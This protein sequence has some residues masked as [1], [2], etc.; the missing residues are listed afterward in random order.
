MP[1]KRTNLGLMVVLALV[2]AS[3]A[4][5]SPTGMIKECPEGCR[6]ID[7]IT[8]CGSED[9]TKSCVMATN[10]DVHIVCI[11][12]AQY[13]LTTDGCSIKPTSAPTDVV[14]WFEMRLKEY[15]S[16]LFAMLA[17]INDQPNTLLMWLQFGAGTYFGLLGMRFAMFSTGVLVMPLAFLVS[18]ALVVGFEVKDSKTRNMIILGTMALSPIL[19]V[20]K[21][22][23]RI[24]IGTLLFTE[25]AVAAALLLSLY[26]PTIPS[27]SL[28]WGVLAVIVFLPPFTAAIPNVTVMACLCLSC[29]LLLVNALW[30]AS[31]HN[32]VLEAFRKPDDR[33]FIGGCAFGAWVVTGLIQYSIFKHM[34]KMAKEEQ[35]M[36]GLLEAEPFAGEIASEST[37]GTA[38]VVAMQI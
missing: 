24:L 6:P 7:K 8:S 16:Q 4:Q 13:A 30:M 14:P 20:L 35:M 11:D 23:R 12:G 28:C 10:G 34:K 33:V 2:V 19:V 18:G 22:L 31:S 1:S 29:S 37:Y 15:H 27:L 25:I 26:V 17:S 9:E 38:V 21:S 5:L 32:S 3:T 36:A